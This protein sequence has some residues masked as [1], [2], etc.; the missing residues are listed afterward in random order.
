MSKSRISLIILGIGIILFVLIKPLVTASDSYVDKTGCATITFTTTA[1]RSDVKIGI[2]GDHTVSDSPCFQI[3]N[4]ADRGHTQ[5][6]VNVLKN[7]SRS[8]QQ[9]VIET[10]KSLQESLTTSVPAGQHTL[11]IPARFAN[12]D[13]ND[14][15]DF[16]A[17]SL[18]AMGVASRHFHGS[19]PHAEIFEPIDNP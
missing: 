19:P 4:D 13:S 15:I 7:D 3:T 8:F 2:F 1:E 18:Y 9:I 6:V 5:V 17:G 10:G 14:L 16:C 11:R 12:S